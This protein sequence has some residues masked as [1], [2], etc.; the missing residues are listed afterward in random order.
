[1]QAGL[2]DTNLLVIASRET[3]VD[4]TKAKKFLVDLVGGRGM[5]LTPQVLLEYYNVMRMYEFGAGVVVKGVNEF[6]MVARMIYPL[7]TTY[8]RALAFAQRHGLKGKAA[9][10]DAY[11]AATA[12][13]NNVKVIYTQ[14]VKDFKKFAGVEAIDPLG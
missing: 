1:M 12:K 4:Y 7:E 6:V 13:D 5:V 9:V 8:K 11:L 10:F 2:I 3:A 14:N